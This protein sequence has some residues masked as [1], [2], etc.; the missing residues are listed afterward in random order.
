MTYVLIGFVQIYP[1][2][3]YSEFMSQPTV[4]NKVY[5]ILSLIVTP[6]LCWAH[7]CSMRTEPGYLSPDDEAPTGTPSDEVKLCAK[8]NSD[9]YSDPDASSI[10]HCSTCKRCVRG[11]DHH[12]TYTNNCVGKDNRA[13]FILFNVYLIFF[14]INNTVQQTR[15]LGSV[16]DGMTSLYDL[17]KLFCGI[18]PLAIIIKIHSLITGEDS[19]LLPS[20]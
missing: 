12:C 5:N 20:F 4:E 14:T 6:L 19:Y 9:R 7:Q 16:E 1:R 3:R 15:A 8:C 11:M 17:P 2:I 10:H 18:P 13:Q